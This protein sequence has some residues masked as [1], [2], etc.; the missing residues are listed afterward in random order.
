[1]KRAA[2][3]LQPVLELRRTQ[4]RTAALAAAQ[5]A[6]DGRRRRPP[7]H[8]SGRRRWPSRGLPPSGCRRRA[9]SPP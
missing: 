9:S 7:G 3:R 1:M 2:F 4:E 6:Q 8:A 5:A